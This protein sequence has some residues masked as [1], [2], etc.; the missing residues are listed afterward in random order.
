MTRFGKRTESL[1]DLFLEAS[2]KALKDSELEDVDAIYVGSMNPDEFTGDSNISA[3]IADH[4]GIM[5]PSLR[6]E[7]SSSTGASVFHAAY[8]AVASGYHEN[9]MVLAGEKMTHLPTQTT[10]T[11]LAKVISPEERA[12]GATMPALAAL[13]TRRYMH[14]FGLDRET[15]A[16]VAVKNHHNGSL[17][18]YAHFQKEIDLDSVI[19]SRIISDPL[20]LYDCAPISDGACAVILSASKGD[21]R[22]SGMGHATDTLAL[23][24]RESLTGFRS[25]QVAARRAYSMAKINASD[26]HVAEVHDAFTTFEIID[27]EDLGFF[28]EGEGGQA[29]RE[30][31]TALDGEMP[32]NPSGGLKARGHPVG[33]SGL[34][35]II[36]IYWQLCGV[37][38][39][40]QVDGARLGLTQSIGGLTNNNLVTILEVC[41]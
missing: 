19:S 12:Y 28:N 13:V 27:C 17:N 26:I 16:L 20:K 40:R 41:E 33:A 10:T 32:I 22:V 3:V 14:T 29:L 8:M 25:T 5:K 4:I 15:L 23:S 35:Q 24:H 31:L 37:A 18:P 6:V 2:H 38:G 21:V 30:G 9:V 7:T 36:E 39:K 11:I 34:A 1:P